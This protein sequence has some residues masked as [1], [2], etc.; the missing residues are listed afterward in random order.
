MPGTFS[1]GEPDSIQ[2]TDQVG[3]KIGCD[4]FIVLVTLIVIGGYVL[5]GA[6]K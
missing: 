2:G 5:L 4:M 6:M 3:G 1:Q